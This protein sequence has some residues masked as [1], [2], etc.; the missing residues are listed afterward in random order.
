MNVTLAVAQKSLENHKTKE[1]N[2][3]KTSHILNDKVDSNH[4]NLNKHQTIVC[5]TCNKRLRNKKYLDALM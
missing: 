1:D 3:H 2:G 4:P 5:E